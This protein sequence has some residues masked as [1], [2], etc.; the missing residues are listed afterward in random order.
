MDKKTLPTTKAIHITEDLV[1]PPN[2]I[3]IQRVKVNKLDEKTILIKNVEL[4]NRIVTANVLTEIK[5]GQA[6]MNI[7][8]LNN[9]TVTL[10]QGTML[11][12]VEYPEKRTYELYVPKERI[13]RKLQNPQC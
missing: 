13:K 10:K 4:K 1:L 5:K 6:W 7:V 3:N 8:N 9:E 11:S 2:T 12:T